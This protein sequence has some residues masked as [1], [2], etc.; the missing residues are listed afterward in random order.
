TRAALRIASLNMKGGGSQGTAH[1][2]RFINQLVR[3]ESLSMITLQ[4]T[5]LTDERRDEIQADFDRLRIFNSPDADAPSRRGGVALILNTHKTQW[6]EADMK[7]LVQG[8]A[9]LIS[10]A[11]GEAAKLKV[12][13]IYAPSGNNEVNKNFW[14]TLNTIWRRKPSLRPDF[15]LGDLNMVE[16]GIDRFPASK[17]NDAVVE[18]FQQMTSDRKLVDG[19][20]L[21]N[22]GGIDY[23]FSTRNTDRVN[24]RSRID[25]IYTKETHLHRCDEWKISE[26]G[27]ETD[28]FMASVYVTTKETPYVGSGRRSIPDFVLDFTEVRTM[29]M[30]RAQVLETEALGTIE[31]SGPALQV[32]WRKFKEDILA[33]VNAYLKSRAI[34]LDTLINK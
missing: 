3:D 33:L 12:A 4:E 7:V 9:I 6:K 1:K 23:T 16:S 11:W 21:A 27:L 5:H 32:L 29:I 30:A 18:S 2:W 13:A 31:L 8:R 26:T 19:W 20:R 25:R 34:D 24:S 22:P 17:D 14:T 10:L 15:M 28:H